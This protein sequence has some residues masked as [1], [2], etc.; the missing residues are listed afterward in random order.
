MLRTLGD[1]WGSL[2]ENIMPHAT[3]FDAVYGR[4]TGR[5]SEPL[6]QDAVKTLRQA[7]DPALFRD[8]VGDSEFA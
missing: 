6:R 5:S 4:E 3:A 8:V 7:L 1:A 2:A